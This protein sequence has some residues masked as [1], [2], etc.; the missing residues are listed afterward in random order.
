MILYVNVV[1]DLALGHGHTMRILEASGCIVNFTVYGQ[2][3]DLDDG[4]ESNSVDSNV[5][6]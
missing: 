1:I 6:R 4:K 5:R 3:C 2:W